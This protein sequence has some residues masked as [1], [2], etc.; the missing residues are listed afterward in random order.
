MPG[1]PSRRG[2]A[3]PAAVP[4]AAPGREQRPPA[5]SPAPERGARPASPPSLL[6]QPEWLSPA[7]AAG[8]HSPAH[9]YS[10]RG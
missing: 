4:G 3:P 10:G 6:P 7:C 2:R 9:E 1:A 8:P 5:R